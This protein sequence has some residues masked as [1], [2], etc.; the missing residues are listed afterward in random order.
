MCSETCDQGLEP[1]DSACSLARNLYCGASPS[2]FFV[3]RSKLFRKAT[4]STAS[5]VWFNASTA[6]LLTS[7]PFAGHNTSGFKAAKR[8]SEFSVGLSPA[9]VQWSQSVV[10]GAHSLPAEVKAPPQNTTFRA[11]SFLCEIAR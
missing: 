6:P 2:R 9:S 3:K 8:V 7:G 10:Y 4:S 1:F 5:A 11:F